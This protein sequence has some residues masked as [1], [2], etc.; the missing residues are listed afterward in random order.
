MTQADPGS[1]QF[2]ILFF[3]WGSLCIYL[4]T[5]LLLLI[6]IISY[7]YYYCITITIIYYHFV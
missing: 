4:P 2:F 5:V 6:I 1:L 7:H 3:L